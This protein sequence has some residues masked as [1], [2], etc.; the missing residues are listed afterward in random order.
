MN[1]YHRQLLINIKKNSRREDLSIHDS[2]RYCGTS[3]K[4]YNFKTE[5]KRRI[6]REFIKKYPSLSFYEYIEL[7]DSLNKGQSYE[8]KT[9]G[10]TLLYLYRDNKKQ[11]LPKHLNKWLENLEGW[12]EIDSLCQSSFSADEILL[13]WVSWEKV[14]ITFSKSDFISKRRASLVLLTKP[15]RDVRNDKFLKI[16]F[17]NMNKLKLEKD[18]LIT[19]AI[20]WLLRDMI[21]N[22]RDEVKNYLKKNRETL[23]KIAVRETT[24]KLETGKK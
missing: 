16:A 10:S 13:N 6:A 4:F 19:K 17:R 22:Y 20:S 7:L 24:R 14:L 23:P 5:V 18:I 9:I 12:A 2:Q 15:V 11:L 1:K 21:K 3:D 8:E